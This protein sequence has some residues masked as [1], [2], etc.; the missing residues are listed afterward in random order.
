[1]VPVTYAGGQ[2]GDLGRGRTEG[3]CWRIL[4]GSE[5]EVWP[6]GEVNA[7]GAVLS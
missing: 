3:E 6:F 5:A 1:M 2:A 7:Q 4:S